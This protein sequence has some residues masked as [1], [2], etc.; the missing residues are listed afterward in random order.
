MLVSVIVLLLRLRS[1]EFAF[2]I[3]RSTTFIRQ[4]VE[5]TRTTIAPCRPENLLICLFALKADMIF[6]VFGFGWQQ[7]AARLSIRP[8]TLH[9][10]AVCG[11]CFSRK[12]NHYRRNRIEFKPRNCR[13]A[14]A[15]CGQCSIERQFHGLFSFSTTK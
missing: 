8:T 15:S 2:E 11:Q 7:I 12:P 13:Q 9:H 3:S 5:F 14:D 1:N 10:L 4:I 6:I